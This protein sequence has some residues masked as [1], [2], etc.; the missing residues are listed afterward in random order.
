MEMKHNPKD[1]QRQIMMSDSL[2]GQIPE[3]DADAATKFLEQ[4]A[5]KYVTVVAEMI[6]AGRIT[7]LTGVLRGILLGTNPE[8]EFR[9]ELSE[10][11]ALLHLNNVIFGKIELHHGLT[12]IP[13]PGPFSVTAARIDEINPQDQMC[14]LG[15]H[16]SPPRR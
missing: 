10:A 4:E 11:L 8:I 3:L 6:T 9:C 1:D 15:L 13:I 14:T 7:G 2:R 16:L 5:D 12:L